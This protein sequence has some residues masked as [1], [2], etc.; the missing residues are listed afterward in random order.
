MREV[1]GRGGVELVSVL[2]H[3]VRRV[4]DTIPV[5]ARPVVGAEIGRPEI[6]IPNHADRQREHA[7]SVWRRVEEIL[8]PLHRLLTPI[9]AAGGLG[10]EEV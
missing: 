8:Q 10:G 9:G 4:A 7:C 2:I 6:Q 3:A 5:R 1:G